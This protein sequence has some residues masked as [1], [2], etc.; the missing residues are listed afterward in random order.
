M[1]SVYVRGRGEDRMS[2][3]LITFLNDLG[4]RFVTIPDDTT[5]LFITLDP[6][7]VLEMLR[8]LSEDAFLV[9]FGTANVEFD[10]PRVRSV[11]P[12][13]ISELSALLG[14]SPRAATKEI[15]SSVGGEEIFA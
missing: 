5:S 7:V 10:D 6:T 3:I 14:M 11:T 8:T 13:R 12:N 9:V 1:Q 15:L 4:I 2:E